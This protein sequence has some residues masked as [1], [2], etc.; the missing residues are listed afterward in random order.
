MN[1]AFHFGRGR[2]SGSHNISASKNHLQETLLDEDNNF[3]FNWGE[4][5]ELEDDEPDLEFIEETVFQTLNSLPLECNHENTFD[6]FIRGAKLIQGE[7][8]EV[9]FLYL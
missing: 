6:S 9:F 1:E 8:I 2:K 5:T 7:E 3:D 4:H